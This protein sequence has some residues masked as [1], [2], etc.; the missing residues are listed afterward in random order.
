VSGYCT[1]MAAGVLGKEDMLTYPYK[2]ER[3]CWP[4]LTERSA[5]SGRR[6][7]CNGQLGRANVTG[8]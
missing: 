6:N 1:V 5:R 3:M 4:S 8:A 7:V 2:E